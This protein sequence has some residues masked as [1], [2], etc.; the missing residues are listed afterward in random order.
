M[1]W[2]VFEAIVGAA[3]GLFVAYVLGLIGY[4]MFLVMMGAIARS[5]GEKR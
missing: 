4:F 2:N 3:C 1:F 5:S